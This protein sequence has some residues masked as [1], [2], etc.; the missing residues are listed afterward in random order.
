M[1]LADSISSW[2]REYLDTAGASGFVFGLSGGVDSAL[3]AGLAARAVGAGA[4]L[5]ALLPC[6]SQPIDADLGQRVGSPR[7]GPQRS[8]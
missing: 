6:Q 1:T 8:L 7:L 4:T 5:G 2:M 3:T